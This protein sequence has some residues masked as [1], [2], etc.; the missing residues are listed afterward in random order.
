MK[1][2]SGKES[3]DEIEFEV[4]CTGLDGC[5]KE[6]CNRIRT[7]NRDKNRC[8]IGLLQTQALALIE[9]EKRQEAV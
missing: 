7:G 2:R 5:G 9:R 3:P 8:G 4:H 1:M 6:N